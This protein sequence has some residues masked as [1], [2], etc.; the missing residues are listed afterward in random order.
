MSDTLG[1]NKMKGIF[2][3]MN[4][5]NVHVFSIPHT[6]EQHVASAIKMS[7]LLKRHNAPKMIFDKLYS[8]ILMPQQ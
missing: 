5:G 4:E 1:P 7:A 2:S 8:D 6:P 3:A